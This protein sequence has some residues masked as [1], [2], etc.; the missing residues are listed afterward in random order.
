MRRSRELSRRIFQRQRWTVPTGKVKWYD[1]EK[2]FG[3]LSD[4]EG[5]DVFLHAN[6][7]P[8]ASTTL[9]GGTRVEFGIV[10]GRRGA[11]A[12]SVTR[13]RPGALASSRR[14]ARADRKPPEEHGRH[15]RGR[16]QAPRRRLQLAAPRTL[17]RQGA[18]QQGRPGA[19]RLA[20][21]SWRPDVPVARR[22]TPT[23]RARVDLAREAAASIAEPGTV[24]EHLGM[25]MVDER[26]ATHYFACT[27]AAYPG[28][29]WA[30]TRRPRAARQGGHGLR[31][32][33]GARRGRAARRPSGC[34]TPSG[35]PPA[36]SAPATCCPTCEDDPNLEP[37]FE[38]T[39]DEDVDQMAIWE[40]GLGRPRV[41]SAEGREAAAQRWYDGEHGPARRGRRARPRRPARP[42]AS[43][44]RW[45]VRCAS[46]FG[47]C[48]NE[49][50]PS[51]GRVV[52]LDHGCGAHS[53][54]DVDQHEPVP[55][56]EPLVDEIAVRPGARLRRPRGACRWARARAAGLATARVVGQWASSALPRPRRT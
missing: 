9:K 26:L 47:V 14:Q 52:S 54:V 17:P 38:A 48:A 23:L 24:G 31:D 15:R 4:D 2:G 35:W 41:L 28:W 13:P 30:V 37:G 55:M 7:L 45:P 3:F 49:W 46:V 18:R 36:T 39:G 5:G 16:H 42:A 6:A 12:L 21:P 32:Q 29:R 43:S 27:A 40:L 33:P 56:G 8:R 11:Q 10:E 20:R 22:P 51:D 19:A 50:S 1:A 44:C 34:R 25:E 53:E